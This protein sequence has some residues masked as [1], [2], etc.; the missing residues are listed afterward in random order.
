MNHV[1][2][3]KLVHELALVRYK[4]ITP[5]FNKHSLRHRSITRPMHHH[6]A[7]PARY[8]DILST[9]SIVVQFSLLWDHG[10]AS[11]QVN[12]LGISAP[13][14]VLPVHCHT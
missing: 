11:T 14:Y 5:T 13:Y 9:R 10:A 3:S 1:V 12:L 6:I 2:R 8:F 7:V 4:D